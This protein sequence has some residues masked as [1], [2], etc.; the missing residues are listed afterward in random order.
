M[1]RKGFSPTTFVLVAV[2]IGALFLVSKTVTP[3]PPAPPEPPKAPAVSP[4]PAPGKGPAAVAANKVDPMAQRKEMMRKMQALSGQKGGPGT[5]GFKPPAKTFNPN[6]IDVTSDYWHQAQMG[7]QGEATMRIKV[8]KAKAEE[9]AHRVS[10][11]PVPALPKPSGARP[12]IT[13]IPPQPAPGASGIGAK[14]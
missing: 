2:L 14:Q 3:P 6:S 5:K 1:G 10:I 4:A 7:S 9:A 12:P 11:A 13:K 8:E